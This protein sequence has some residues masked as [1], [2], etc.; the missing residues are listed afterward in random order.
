MLLEGLGGARPMA[1]RLTNE[2]QKRKPN[3][4]E[5]N[6]HRGKRLHF[7]TIFPLHGEQLR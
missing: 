5:S 6:M 7:H 2:S 4:Q 3:T 1:S